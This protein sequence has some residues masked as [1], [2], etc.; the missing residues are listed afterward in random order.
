MNTLQNTYFDRCHLSKSA[1]VRARINA[2]LKVD[3]EAV[4]MRLGLTMSDAI[5]LYLAQIKLKGGIPFEIKI[6]NKETLCAMEE[7]EK[8][9]G[10]IESHSIEDFFKKTGLSNAKNKAQKII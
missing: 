3:V 5:N 10:L 4:L 2:D 7:T 6:P 8:G 9:I 1:V